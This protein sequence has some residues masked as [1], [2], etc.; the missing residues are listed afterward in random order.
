MILN[1]SYSYSRS[2]HNY[3]VHAIAHFFNDCFIEI[4]QY[5]ATSRTTPLCGKRRVEHERKTGLV[6]PPRHPCA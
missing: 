4:P 1:F 3:H 5:G 6:L 2:I